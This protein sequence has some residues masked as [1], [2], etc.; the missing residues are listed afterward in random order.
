MARYHYPYQKIVDL[1]KSEKTQ[2]E[3]MLSTAL[4]KLQSE[5]QK[6]DQ[7]LL[8]RAAW[9]EKLHNA[10]MQIVTLS[11]LT[12]L[13]S[14]LDHIDECIAKKYNDVHTAKSEVELEQSRLSVKMKD[15]KVWLKAKEQAFHRFS[16]TMQLKEQ[17][18]LDEMATARYMI[19]AQ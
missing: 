16:H 2:A 15:E 19:P 6:L 10:S 11:E 7:L 9:Q 5:E 8:D 4:G 18:E 17:N 14:Y 1:K 3:W 13:Q 12:L